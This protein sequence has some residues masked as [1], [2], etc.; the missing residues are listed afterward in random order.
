VNHE[1]RRPG[2]GNERF[3]EGKVDARLVFELEPG[4]P[5]LQSAVSSQRRGSDQR[6][7][8]PGSTEISFP[9]RAYATC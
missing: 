4:E 6:W 5:A 9:D 2:S 8:K 7:E 1:T 3:E